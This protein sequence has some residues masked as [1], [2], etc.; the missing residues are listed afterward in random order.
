MIDNDRC[1]IVEAIKSLPVYRFSVVVFTFFGS[2]GWFKTFLR[3][4]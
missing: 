2:L 3:A 4:Q 1:K